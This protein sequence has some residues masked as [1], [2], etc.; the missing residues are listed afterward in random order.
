MKSV[1]MQ[2]RDLANRDKRWEEKMKNKQKNEVKVSVVIPVYNAEKYL[3][4]C[5]DSVLG[6]SLNEIEVICVDDGSEDSSYDILTEYSSRDER[7][8]CAR[9]NNQGA[10]PARN[11]ALRMAEG[12]YV[13]FMDSDDEYPTTDVLEKM[14]SAVRTNNCR[15]CGGMRM[16]LDENLELIQSNDP[17]GLLKNAYPSG[18]W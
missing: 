18:G 17:I 6:Q 9:Q 8:K 13:C 2:F 5:L 7:V 14:Y 1:N 11:C 16:I 15:V 10:G 12:Q 3:R 4:T